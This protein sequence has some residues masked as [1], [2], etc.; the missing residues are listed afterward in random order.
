MR[1][2]VIYSKVGIGKNVQVG[3]IQ[4]GKRREVLRQRIGKRRDVIKV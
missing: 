1:E 2:E 3:Y 4:C